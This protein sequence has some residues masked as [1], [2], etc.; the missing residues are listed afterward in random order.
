MQTFNN[1]F[2]VKISYTFETEEK[3]YFIMEYL[4]GGRL[5]YHLNIEQKFSEDKV[6][7]YAAQIVLALSYLH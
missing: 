6:K 3:Y 5:F 4:S 7:V 2:I 1:P